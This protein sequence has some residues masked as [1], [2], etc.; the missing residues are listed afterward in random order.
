[1]HQSRVNE[2]TLHIIPQNQENIVKQERVN[3][4][5]DPA[6]IILYEEREIP[7]PTHGYNLRKLPQACAL[8]NETT[9]TLEEYGAL[10]KVPQKETWEKSYANDLGRLA[11]GVNGRIAGTNRVFF[12]THNEVPKKKIT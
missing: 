11:Q 7:R 3:K 8:I 6:N 12:I 10:A 2:K 4:T 9:S 5:P 1:M